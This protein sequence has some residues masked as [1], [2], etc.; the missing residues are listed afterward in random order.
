MR[1]A[2][3]QNDHQF[4]ENIKIV[5]L[6]LCSMRLALSGGKIM[7]QHEYIG[8]ILPDGGLTI[9]GETRDRFAVG[10]KVRVMIKPIPT[11]DKKPLEQ[12]DPATKRLL[13]RIRNAKPIGVPDDPQLL[14]HSKLAEERLNEKFPWKG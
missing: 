6:A 11:P 10:E 9:H 4:P 5:R 7:E 3:L 14:S 13:E 2:I 1:S 8:E 12:L